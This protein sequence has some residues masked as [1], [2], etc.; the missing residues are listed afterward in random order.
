[1]RAAISFLVYTVLVL[2]IPTYGTFIYDRIKAR[3]WKNVVK[4][5]LVALLIVCIVFF[6]G[7]Y[8]LAAQTAAAAKTTPRLE[9]LNERDYEAEI[10]LR[11]QKSTLTSVDQAL[12]VIKT[13]FD[14]AEYAHS[15]F[16]DYKG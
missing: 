16:E 15:R 7:W 6:L 8:G 11:R 10:N 13:K 2:A 1:M 4:H 14:E 9:Y 12:Q 5:G 3:D